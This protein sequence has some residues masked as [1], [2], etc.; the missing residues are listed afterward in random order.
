[1]DNIL[2]RGAGGPEFVPCIP[3]KVK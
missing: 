3:H 2:A 1:M